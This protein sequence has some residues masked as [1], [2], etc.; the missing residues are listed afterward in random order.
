MATIQ[1]PKTTLAA[2]GSNGQ[3]AVTVTGM[4][5]FDSG[6]V[7]KTFKLEIG[8]YGDDSTSDLRPAGDGAGDDLLYTFSFAGGLF[9]RPYKLLT[10][11]AAGSVP[12]NETRLVS[13]EKLD[14]DSGKV[15]VGQPT[16]QEFVFMPRS[17]EVYAKLTLG[18]TSISAVSPT[19]QA[20][21]GV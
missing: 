16:F 11:Q 3:R 19:V 4:L 2:G 14:E 8:L 12:V 6:D 13:D 18:A 9:P 7:G 20:G 1:N 5:N 15:A 17:D 21:I 10:V